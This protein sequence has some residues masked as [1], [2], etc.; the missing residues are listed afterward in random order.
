MKKILV[1]LLMINFTLLGYPRNIKCYLYEIK[2]N[3]LVLKK[4][5]NKPIIPGSGQGV[6]I[7]DKNKKPTKT[8][9]D[10]LKKNILKKY[11]AKMK[12]N[13]MTETR[14]KKI[15]EKYLSSDKGKQI[16][17]DIIQKIK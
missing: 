2:D 16:I 11:K 4:I 12:E 8:Q 1:I 6:I 14:I 17:K 10:N 15:I 3:E 13:V 9:L 7:L 5:S